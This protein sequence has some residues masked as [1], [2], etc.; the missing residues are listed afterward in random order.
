MCKRLSNFSF[1]MNPSC[2]MGLN[3]LKLIVPPIQSVPVQGL[4]LTST[5]STPFFF[6]PFPRFASVHPTYDVPRFCSQWLQR[7]S[8]VPL[9][10][11]HCP[12]EVTA[13]RED[14]RGI[15]TIIPLLILPIILCHRCTC[16]PNASP[17]LLSLLSSS[18]C[19]CYHI[20]SPYCCST[21]AIHSYRD[22]PPSIKTSFLIIPDVVALVRKR[23]TAL[24]ETFQGHDKKNV[25][26]TFVA[27]FTTHTYST[28]GEWGAAAA[29][30]PGGTTEESPQVSV[31]DQRRRGQSIASK[32]TGGEGVF[33]VLSLCLFVCVCQ[34]ARRC[35]CFSSFIFVSFWHWE[36]G[37]FCKERT[38]RLVITSAKDCFGAEALFQYWCQACYDG[39]S[40]FL[41][42][43]NVGLIFV[44]LSK[45]SRL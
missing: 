38:F 23:N 26:D 9:P 3:I 27:S 32:M 42:H 21:H 2:H 4:F 24:E 11:P 15:W 37:H 22:P 31:T 5:C 34:C 28:H 43:Y 16:S 45:I 8:A 35:A 14:K 39:Y 20:S 36:W 41:T 33:V 25:C 19:R 18:H 44:I 13:Q 7:I 17:L 29:Q 10:C 12:G 30:T 6:L 1:P 40:I